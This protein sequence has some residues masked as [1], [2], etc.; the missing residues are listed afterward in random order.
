ML[1]WNTIDVSFARGSFILRRERLLV[2]EFKTTVGHI[3]SSNSLE[4]LKRKNLDRF[5]K[6]PQLFL[7]LHVDN[8]AQ[9]GL[10]FAHCFA[11]SLHNL[12]Q[13]DDQVICG[14]TNFGEL[15]LLLGCV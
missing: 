3:V 4:H 1:Y 15:G 12:D 10:T 6:R 2:H 8:L 9:D 11:S 5:L 14:D 13:R 7:R